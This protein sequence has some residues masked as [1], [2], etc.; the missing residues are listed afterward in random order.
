MSFFHLSIFRFL[1]DNPA[2]RKRLREYNALLR[3]AAELCFAA[4][5]SFCGGVSRSRARLTRKNSHFPPALR[6][7]RNSRPAQ[8]AL[9]EKRGF[10][11]REFSFIWV[12][13]HAA[14]RNVCEAPLCGSMSKHFTCPLVAQRFE[15]TFHVFAKAKTFHFSAERKGGANV[16]LLSAEKFHVLRKGAQLRII[17]I[18]PLCRTLPACLF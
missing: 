16:T 13:R 3:V 17:L 6:S 8:G 10:R 11:W 14:S 15:G 18:A 5:F 1:S 4:R 7:V 9:T 12:Q 2:I